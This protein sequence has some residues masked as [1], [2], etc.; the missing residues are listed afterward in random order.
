[1]T[2]GTR[3]RIYPQSGGGWAEPETI[4]L[5]PPVGTVGPGPSDRMLR[6][7]LPVAKLHPYDP[8]AYLPPYTGP[9]L[10]PAR[11]DRA[12]HFDHIAVTDPAFMPAHIYACVRHT[13]D[14]WEG[15]LGPVT[16]WHAAEYPQL[17]LAAVVEW[18]NA[19]SGMG[20]IETGHRPNRHGVEQYFCLN[21][22]V[23]GHEAGHALLFSTLGAPAPE[24]LTAEFL[25]F[26]ESFSDL[27]ALVAALHLPSVADRLLLQTGGNLY[28]LNLLNRVGE[29]SDSE[30][31]RIADNVT[32]LRDLDGLR[33]LP[34]G[35]WHDPAGLDR[36][37]H[38]LA[39]PLTGALFD[40]LVEAYQAGLVARGALPPRLDA[41]AWTREEVAAAFAPVQSASAASLGAFSRA[42]H[43][44]LRDARDLLARCMA[45]V[46]LTLRADDVTFAAVAAAV[47]RAATHQGHGWQAPAFVEIFLLRGIDPRPALRAGWQDEQ[48]GAREW[49][50]LPYSERVRRM[51]QAR[52][53]SRGCLCPQHRL[54]L[55][56]NFVR[57]PQRAH[58][59]RL[60]P[61]AEVGAP[62]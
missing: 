10:P 22:D 17:E 40:L 1:M 13:L 26:H 34:D 41:R 8:P 27:A 2:G 12:G 3:F 56:N 39:Q 44:A 55:A 15:Y 29:M 49:K 14:A 21:F 37:A 32:T 36:N 53:P 31:V 11:P 52:R 47:I 48:R 46:M 30:Q 62:R 60:P 35:S 4:T 45:H 58:P 42:F 20:F 24:R 16:W 43:G 9:C 54:L 18:N 38:A 61:M 33:L 50:G 6:A 5:S 25:A 28:V 19:Q 57:H 7:I 51:A 23:V 59:R